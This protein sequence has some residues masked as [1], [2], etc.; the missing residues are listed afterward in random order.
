MSCGRGG[1]ALECLVAVQRGGG[2]RPAGAQTQINTS[3]LP[4]SALPA[5]LLPHRSMDNK[6]G[7]WADPAVMSGNDTAYFVSRLA[8]IN[9][10]V[11]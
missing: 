11:R 9:G 6:Q 10:T 3:P 4:T 1:G 8:G 7:D 2:G 5:A